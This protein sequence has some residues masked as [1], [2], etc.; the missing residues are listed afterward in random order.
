MA[1]INPDV[2]FIPLNIAVMV[3]SDSRDESDD[4]SGKMLE[5]LLTADGHN[6]AEKKIVI[7]D[8]YE[9][10]AAVS[11]W[12][13]DPDVHAVITTGGTGLTGRDVTPE[14]MKVLYDKEIEGFGE[15]FRMISYDLIKTS[16]IQSRA[17]AGLANGTVLFTLPGSPGACKDGWQEIIKHQLDVRVMPCN[18][19]QMMPRFKEK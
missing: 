14:A 9:I 15:V 8:I 5:K 19:V 12:I 4:K 13:A 11:Q 16:T 6:L 1:K 7:D 18:L 10:R 2:D 17:I 3:V